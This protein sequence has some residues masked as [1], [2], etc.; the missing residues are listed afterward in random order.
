MGFDCLID[1]S[2]PDGTGIT[3]A[4]VLIMA[5]YTFLEEL[6]DKKMTDLCRKAYLCMHIEHDFLHV[7]RGVGDHTVSVRAKEDCV[8]LL[9]CR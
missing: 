2:F 9:D 1:S 4:T 7:T 3:N 5:F 6:T 8:L